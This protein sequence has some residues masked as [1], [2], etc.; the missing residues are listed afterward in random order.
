M[1][2]LFDLIEFF[3]LLVGQDRADL[4]IRPV[5]CVPQFA[6]VLRMRHA[7][8][9]YKLHRGIAQLL[10]DRI[11]FFLLFAVE[12]KLLGEKFELHFS[13]RHDGVIAT[14]RAFGWTAAAGVS[15]LRGYG[16]SE[17]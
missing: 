12:I 11:H 5:A 14:G 17:R 13:G 4:F 10:Q 15:L 3:L 16:E 8:V 9:L 2:L 7:V 1:W 6:D